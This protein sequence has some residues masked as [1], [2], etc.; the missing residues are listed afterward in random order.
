MSY[1]FVSKEDMAMKFYPFLN[2]A[3][4]FKCAKFPVRDLIWDGDIAVCGN[5][6]LLVIEWRP[7][8]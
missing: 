8:P 2:L 1:N 6:I 5:K 3:S 4:I 7:C